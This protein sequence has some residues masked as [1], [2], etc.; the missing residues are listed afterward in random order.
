MVHGPI[1]IWVQ[2]TAGE[3]ATTTS[4]AHPQVVLTPTAGIG[5]GVTV[6]F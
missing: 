2:L 3:G 5:V 1:Q 4:G 6:T